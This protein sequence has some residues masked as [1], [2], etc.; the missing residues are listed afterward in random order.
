MNMFGRVAI[1]LTLF[2]TFN[3]TYQNIAVA[4]SDEQTCKNAARQK[5]QETDFGSDT[6]NKTKPVIVPLALPRIMNI[7]KSSN[8]GELNSSDDR[9][10]AIK[11]E[12]EAKNIKWIVRNPDRVSREAVTQIES[13]LESECQDTK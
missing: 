9:F 5:L 11:Q 1:L 7:I 6:A 3:G 8:R 2:S 4:S 13:L 10:K 12:L